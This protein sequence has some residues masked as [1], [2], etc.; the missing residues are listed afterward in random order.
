[1]ADMLI[2]QVGYDP[3]GTLC[4]LS[5]LLAYLCAQKFRLN[6]Q[7][8]Q[9]MCPVKGA[10]AADSESVK[11]A[12]AESAK[13]KAFTSELAAN[14]FIVASNFTPSRDSLS[15]ETVLHEVAD[16]LVATSLIS[17]TIC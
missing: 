10:A 11:S 4:R 8:L 5:S 13:L 15:L 1:M 16:N 7:G 14:Y 9:A 3:N 12:S 17:P 6:A 2:N